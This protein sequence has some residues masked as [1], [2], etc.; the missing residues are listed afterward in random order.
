M[1]CI[2]EFF[3]SDATELHVRSTK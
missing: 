3:Q 1:F 2:V